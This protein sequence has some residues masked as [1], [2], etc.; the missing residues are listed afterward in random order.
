[1]RK[2]VNTNLAR[3]WVLSPNLM[4]AVYYRIKAN[5]IELIRKHI[6]LCSER[7]G[8]KKYYIRDIRLLKSASRAA[9]E[10][11]RNHSAAA[12]AVIV[13]DGLSKMLGNM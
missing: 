4:K 10:Y 11:L 5:D 3:V 2:E 6:R 8:Q 13:G 12:A 9:R 7:F 1:M